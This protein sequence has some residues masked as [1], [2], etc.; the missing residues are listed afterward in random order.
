[1]AFKLN[2]ISGFGNQAVASTLNII[3]IPYYIKY[4]GIESFGLIGIMLLLQTFF[5]VADIGLGATLTRNIA[6]CDV[7]EKSRNSASNLIKSIEIISIAT[8]LII[9]SIIVLGSSLASNIWIKPTAI[10]TSEIAKIFYCFSIIISCKF[11]EGIYKSGL[12]G[13]NQH[14]VYNLIASINNVSRTIL[15]IVLIVYIAQDVIYF[16]ILQA[17]FAIISVVCLKLAF[18][19]NTPYYLKFGV[20]SRSELI[21]NKKFMLGIFLSSLISLSIT[22]VDKL[23]LTKILSLSQYGHYMLAFSAAGILYIVA[24]PVTQAYYPR[25]CRLIA[26]EK[27]NELTIIIQQCTRLLTILVSAILVTLLIGSVDI[28]NFWLKNENL[29]N[30]INVM[31][32]VISLGNFASCINLIISNLSHALGNT[33]TPNIINIMIMVCVIP[34]LLCVVPIWGGEGAASIW[35]IMALTQLIFMTIY[36]NK[37]KSFDRIKWA[38]CNVAWPMIA[39]LMIIMIIYQSIVWSS[40]VQIKVLSLLISVFIG[41]ITSLMIF[42]DTRNLIL[43]RS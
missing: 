36:F 23:I 2:I 24:Y 8:S 33:S 21:K 14:T 35:A 12:M 26:L 4:L 22:Q 43:V 39:T 34:V 1:M 10:D 37:L 7:S 19:R 3:S 41:T 13:L 20:F 18:Y 29:S 27:Y 42:S 11:L 32:I 17:I 9:I 5:N 25:M 16:F 30:Q 6:S 28:L 38:T 15:S 40:L 31:L